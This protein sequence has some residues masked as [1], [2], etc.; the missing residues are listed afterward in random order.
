MIK[1][2]IF[3]L[4]IFFF[5]NKNLISNPQTL[6]G[7]SNLT[8]QIF[9]ELSFEK[10]NNHYCEVS[11]TVKNVNTGTITF[12]MPVWTPGSYLVREFAKN[13]Q[14]VSAKS[15]I[16]KELPIEKINKNSWSVETNGENGLI[17]SYRVYCNEVS[18]RTSHI[19]EDHAFISGSGVFMFVRGMEDKKCVLKIDLPRQWSKVSTG[20]DREGSNLYSARDYTVFIDS[21]VE[22]GNQETFQF[23]VKGIDHEIA[24]RGKGNF[25]KDT[26]QKDFKK[27][28]EEQVKFFG[29][30]IPYSH[31]TFIII[32]TEK[33]RG[34]LEHLNSFVAMSPRWLF[35]DEKE[36]NR[37]L[38]LI[39]H[40][41]F[42]TWNVK[43][44][45]PATLGPFDYDSENY[46]RSLWVAE[47]FTSF[48]DNLFLRR[49][50]IINDK[51]YYEML[52]NEIN[53]VLPFA[54]Y[55]Y[56][57]L[58]ESSFDTWIKF[59]R[60]T[61]N[62]YNSEISY[63][64]KGALIAIML[65]LEIIKITKGKKSL[66]DV[67]N[68]LW[69]EYKNDNTKGFTDEDVKKI[70]EEIAGINLSE[71][72]D[73]YIK[74]TDELPLKKY[75]SYAGLELINE[76]KD[77][78]ASLGIVIRDDNGR[79]TISRV[80]RGGS[81]F[82]SGLNVNDEIIAIDGVRVGKDD[83]EK[84]L[85]DYSTGGKIKLLINRDGFIREI[86]VTLSQPLP[87]FKIDETEKKSSDQK[88]ILK[89]WIEG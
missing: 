10:P 22:I 88:L 77:S 46:T 80:Y 15:T 86:E 50:G 38:G 62:F 81:G 87:K 72:W 52:L 23:K 2:Q 9:Y 66:D 64:T 40:E 24:V 39:S 33:A 26:L 44:I 20:L 12:S 19:T 63:Y 75:L 43:R 27:I 4:L 84:R 30:D 35:N 83:I 1:L 11:I 55:K 29:G 61:E 25:N 16:G 58:E 32:L 82:E 60:R 59:Y 65:N 34:G 37:F 76:I 17:F 31:F 3:F 85:K 70:A 5:L 42:H 45:R 56:Q 49:A 67:M 41:F 14:E 6:K 21:P 71:F 74:G 47:G 48:Y 51:Q 78:D 69:R 73:K 28:V 89:K 18:V 13:V 68:A 54:G 79:A 57:S 53:D 36:Y 8:D 7:N